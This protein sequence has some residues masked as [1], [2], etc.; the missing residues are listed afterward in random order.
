MNFFRFSWIMVWRVTVGDPL[1]QLALGRQF[2]VQQQVGHFQEAAFFG[3]L[4][5][6]IA[7]V[8]QDSAVAIQVGNGALAGGRVEERGI[9][10]QQAE[11]FWAGL[12]LPQVGGANDNR[13]G[14]EG[15]RSFQ[16]GC[17]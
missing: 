13:P 2:A 14:E 6:G 5:D 3:K 17:R 7:A 11:V 12:D 16:C 10:A 9:V 1:I 15:S 4:L 8:A